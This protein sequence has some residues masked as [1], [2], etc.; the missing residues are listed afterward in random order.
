MKKHS[1][2]DISGFFDLKSG[3]LYSHTLLAKQK[4]MAY[5]LRESSI[6]SR[7]HKS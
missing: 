6:F 7:N 4:E 5:E 3:I 1:F 2:I